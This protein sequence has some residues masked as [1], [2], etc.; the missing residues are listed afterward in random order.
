MDT[1]MS[2][3]NKIRSK[4]FMKDP[5]ASTGCQISRLAMEEM[6]VEIDVIAVI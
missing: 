2:E 1:Q 6:L 5:P 3:Y 4:Y